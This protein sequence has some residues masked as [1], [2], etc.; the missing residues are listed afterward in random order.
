MIRACVVLVAWI[1]LGAGAASAANDLPRDRPGRAFFEQGEANFNR[2]RFEEARADY[3]AA[4]DAEPLPAFLF[5][6][7]QCYRNLG[8]Y[9]RA[10]FFFQRYTMLDPRSPNRP[11]AERLI[12][13][14]SRL[15]EE[16]RSDPTA[17]VA[18]TALLTPPSTAAARGPGGAPLVGSVVDTRS[19]GAGRPIYRRTW[20]WVAV[21]GAVV[22]GGAVAL[23][24]SRDAP[25]GTLP[26]IDA[27][28]AHGPH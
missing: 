20:F 26:P 16:R 18:A 21:G 5:N 7:G 27:R 2:G 3:Q 15:A 24:L 9:E 28:D 19:T 13:E 14:M 4:Y 1:A 23:A 11:A 8:E 17:P 6:I 10:Q 22:V 12:A 25:T